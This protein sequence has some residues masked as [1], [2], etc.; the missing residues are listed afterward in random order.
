MVTPNID[1]ANKKDIISLMYALDNYQSRI[2][3]LTDESTETEIAL[4]DD[5]VKSVIDNLIDIELSFKRNKLEKQI[6]GDKFM[7]L[8]A[9]PNLKSLVSDVSPEYLD[10]AHH[11]VKKRILGRK[12]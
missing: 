2:N 9:E 1:F 11:E 3:I 6:Y 5:S 7:D 8:I 12:R 10:Y 4:V